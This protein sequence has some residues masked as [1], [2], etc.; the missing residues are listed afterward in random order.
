MAEA[1]T[2]PGLYLMDG[3][4]FSPESL[5]GF[6]AAGA[7]LMLFTTGPGNSYASAI[8]PTIK[9]TAQVETVRRLAGADRFRR[10]RGGGGRA[11]PWRMPA[12][13]CSKPFSTL[14]KAR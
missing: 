5:T 13:G 2:A 7:Q 10:Q 4:A 9:I 8:A 12:A 11:K 1:P 3:P 14:R 6:A